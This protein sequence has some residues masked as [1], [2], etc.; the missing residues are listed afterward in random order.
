MG[1][2]SRFVRRGL[3]IEYLSLFWMTIE[4]AVALWAGFLASSLALLAFGGDSIIELIS[5]WTVIT[6]LRRREKGQ[7]VD[8]QK[9]E[10]ITTLLLFSLVPAIALGLCY[11][12]LTGVRAESSVLGIGM[13]LGSV[14]IMPV[15]AIE[16]SRIG[17]RGNLLPLSIDAVES[18]TCF[19]MSLALLGGL[20]A[21]YLWNF[22][23]VDTVAACIILVFI[24]REALEALHEVRR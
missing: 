14:I 24:V 5:S 9:A 6:Y 15:L 23:W 3:L 8:E 17:G 2:Q 20:S 11:S 10:W 4:T 12:Y 22:W 1:K 7:T 18:W 13:A 21:N 16:K 19:L